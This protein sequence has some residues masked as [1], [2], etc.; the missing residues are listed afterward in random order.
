MRPAPLTS[1]DFGFPH[2]KTRRWDRDPGKALPTCKC[3]KVSGPFP[4]RLLCP[5]CPSVGV[6]PGPSRVPCFPALATVYQGAGWEFGQEPVHIV[7]SRHLG[8]LP[9]PE[10]T[11]VTPRAERAGSLPASPSTEEGLAGTV[12]QTTSPSR[13]KSR[14]AEGRVGLGDWRQ[15][16]PISLD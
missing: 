15:K 11:Q 10:M 6:L 14:P 1:L 3:R 5:N 7:R 13:N 12:E 4:E 16:S 8:L 2:C 9:R